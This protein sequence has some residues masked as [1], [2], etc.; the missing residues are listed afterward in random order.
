MTFVSDPDVVFAIAEHYGLAEQN[1]KSAP[2][3]CGNV[4]TII[5][6]EVARTIEANLGSAFNRVHSATT[7]Y[8]PTPRGS[9]RL[10]RKSR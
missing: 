7:C 5:I 8:G 9:L 3:V 6:V 4:S 10:W 1:K 2:D